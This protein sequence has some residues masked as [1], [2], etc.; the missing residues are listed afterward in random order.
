MKKGVIVLW[1]GEKLGDGVEIED[2]VR[3]RQQEK[4]WRMYMTECHTNDR[5]KNKRTKKQKNKWADRYE[6]WEYGENGGQ[7]L[8]QEV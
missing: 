4:R 5:Q 2:R 7:R 1:K 3:E 8:R 6:E